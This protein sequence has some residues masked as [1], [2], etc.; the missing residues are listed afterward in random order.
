MKIT[1]TLTVRR[2]VPELQIFYEVID[3]SEIIYNLQ[4]TI[5]DLTPYVLTLEEIEAYKCFRRIVAKSTL[6]A[7]ERLATINSAKN[8]PNP[9]PL[10]SLIINASYN[11]KLPVTIFSIDDF[12]AVQLRFSKPGEV[13]ESREGRI[14]LPAGSLVADTS[15]GILGQFGIKSSPLGKLASNTKKVVVLS[16]GVNETTAVKSKDLVNILTTS[17]TNKGDIK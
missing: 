3:K 15:R 16:F 11:T 6:L 4:G 14:K 1:T 9:D 5:L 8:L 2:A 7:V 17:L 12:N 13:M 10:T